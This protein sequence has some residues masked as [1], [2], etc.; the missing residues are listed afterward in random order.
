M[1][2]GGGSSQAQ[3]SEGKRFAAPTLADPIERAS[4]LEGGPARI[5]PM[6]RRVRSFRA[7]IAGPIA[8][9]MVVLSVAVP[10]M[11]R[12]EHT[13]D[14]AVESSHDPGRC[15]TPHDHTV[16]VQFSG[17]QATTSDQVARVPFRAVLRIRAALAADGVMDGGFVP[18]S[19]ARAPPTA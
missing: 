8:T 10:L 2:A 13:P 18:R 4:T 15:P 7:T 16:C 3:R 11:E 17:N 1:N 5:T 19:S 6:T 9:L 14:A 12:G